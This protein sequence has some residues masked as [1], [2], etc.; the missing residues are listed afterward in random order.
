[1]LL[2][3]SRGVL[4]TG[5]ANFRARDGQVYRP[6]TPVIQDGKIYE[7]FHSP[8]TAY[9]AGYLGPQ[10]PG[11][12]AG[13]AHTSFLGG[14]GVWLSK[15]YQKPEKAQA[16][17]Q[18]AS[19]TKKISTYALGVAQNVAGIGETIPILFG[20]RTNTSGG[21]VVT[22]N[23]IYQRMHSAGGHEWLRAAYIIGEGG[24]GL[25]SPSLTGIRLGSKIIDKDLSCFFSFST[26]TGATANN[27][28]T[29]SN[30]TSHGLFKSYIELSSNN[31]HL[32]GTINKSEV[33]AFS[34]T[35][36]S[37]ETFGLDNEELDCEESECN[38][39]PPAPG[40]TPFSLRTR[41]AFVSNTRSCEVT[42]IG[43]AISL[44]IKPGAQDPVDPAPPGSVWVNNYPTTPVVVKILSPV[45]YMAAIAAS[46]FSSNSTL[47]NT[48]LNIHQRDYA[49]GKRFYRPLNANQRPTLFNTSQDS[50]FVSKIGTQYVPYTGANRP[51]NQ[52]T[53]IGAVVPS[54]DPCILPDLR[55]ILSDIN[56]PKMAFEIY[57]R[58]V[59]NTS[60][61]SWRLLTDKPLVIV[62][63]SEAVM[64]SNI[65]IQHPSLSAV[66]FK[67]VP[68]HP[69]D[70]ERQYLKNMGQTLGFGN[71]AYNKQSISAHPIIYSRNTPIRHVDLLDG[72]KLTFNGDVTTFVTRMNLADNIQNY[73]VGISYINEVMQDS[74]KYPYM[75]VAV[76]NLRGFKGLS[77]AAQLSLYY[78]DGAPINLIETG[79]TGATNMF[80]ELS[81]YLLTT[82]PGAS[83]SIPASAIDTASFIKAIKF[84][85]A[86]GLFFDGVITEK[87]GAFEFIAAYAEY[88][89]LRFGMNQGKYAF[90]IVTEDSSLGTSSAAATQVLTLDDI[91]A[92]SYSVEY[93]T[94]Q[95][96][97]EAFVNITY[98]IQEQNMLGEDRTVTV[99][100]A[101]YTG[102]NVI[103]YD[104]SNFCTTEN[105]AVTY[106]R[107]VL[108]T[109]IKQTHTV[110][111]TTFLGR[112]NLSPGRLF[113]F[114]LSVTTNLGK[115]YTNTEQY[116]IISSVYQSNGTV[117]VQAIHM[118]TDL[119][120]VVFGNTFKVVT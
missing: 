14:A 88:F 79:G 91:I 17:A 86:K 59:E 58:S 50:N 66:N 74:A 7:Y 100:P 12:H 69:D 77:T 3:Q 38:V 11:G 99:A 28:P 48:T 116:Q 63:T 44:A 98:R 49:N 117:Q 84:T 110:S 37:N 112:I 93:K 72:F 27:D 105:H 51:R 6:G 46:G 47:Y 52:N 87:T 57:W 36:G 96:R 82:F 56:N 18:P 75:A 115:T 120:S 16:Q 83:G 61:N 113:R 10:T 67:L 41:T 81:N 64:F 95:D 35:I 108:A 114:N 22:P 55:G 42:E 68:I 15:E 89:L 92:D 104:L 62:T 45:E 39:G 2:N 31:E 109:R 4:I 71:F 20:R 40:I 76:L 26:T 32:T 9:H 80:P 90:T 24:L 34:Q 107:Y 43:L 25:G 30:T 106:A 78:N 23:A 13:L 29:A 53:A 94:L 118:P 102:S 65:K 8:L 119:S 70:F 19:P 60:T 21:I 5:S 1:M 103:Y 54:P 111:F 97:E 73:T 33:R 101:G 85:R